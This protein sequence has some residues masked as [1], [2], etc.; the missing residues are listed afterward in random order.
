[1]FFHIY[2]IHVP[3]ENILN[4]HHSFVHTTEDTI[5][6]YVTFYHRTDYSFT[7]IHTY[8]F[9]LTTF[10]KVRLKLTYCALGEQFCKFSI[11]T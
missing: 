11:I 7:Y 10:L 5:Y 9:T 8:I 6:V 3:M 2:T 1:M 4:V